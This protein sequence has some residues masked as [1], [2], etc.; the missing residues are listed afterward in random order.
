MSDIV[1]V[2]TS[3]LTAYALAR[4]APRPLKR[5]YGKREAMMN[6]LVEEYRSARAF[7]DQRTEEARASQ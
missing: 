5:L 1:T 2:M 6:R 4:H 7:R 3:V